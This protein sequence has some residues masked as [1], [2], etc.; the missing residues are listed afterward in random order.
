MEKIKLI[1][2]SAVG[3]FVTPAH[4]EGASESNSNAGVATV[5]G[6]LKHP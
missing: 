2:L 5:V 4:S 3:T 6:K 1:D